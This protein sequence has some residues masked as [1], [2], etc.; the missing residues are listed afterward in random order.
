MFSKMF[1]IRIYLSI[2]FTWLFLESPALSHSTENEIIKCNEIGNKGGAK[3]CVIKMKN[4]PKGSVVSFYSKH[5]YWVASGT[6]HKPF[7]N[8]AIVIIENAG[9]KIH[10]DLIVEI[11]SQS[12][13][14]KSVY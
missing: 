11:G 1:N 10:K 4:A 9:D 13:D 8:Y 3:A 6:V 5:Y 12:N 7:K 2:T 14:W